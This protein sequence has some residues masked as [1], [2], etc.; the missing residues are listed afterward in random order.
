MET[1][2]KGCLCAI[3]LVTVIDFGRFTSKYCSAKNSEIPYCLLLKT[4]S[5]EFIKYAKY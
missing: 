1:F 5:L 4:W 3:G 2:G